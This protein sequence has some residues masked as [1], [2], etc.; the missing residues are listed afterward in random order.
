MKIYTFFILITIASLAAAQDQTPSYD[1][2]LLA[3]HTQNLCS[4]GAKL[5]TTYGSVYLK[6][7]GNNRSGI[8]ADLALDMARQ[9]NIMEDNVSI[10]MRQDYLVHQQGICQFAIQGLRLGIKLND[11]VKSFAALCRD[12]RPTAIDGNLADIVTIEMMIDAAKSASG[13]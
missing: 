8:C 11:L 12:N 3:K 6:T 2:K 10:V 4:L 13:D 7:T 5:I 9:R 1:N